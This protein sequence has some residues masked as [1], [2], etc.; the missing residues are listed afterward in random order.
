MQNSSPTQEKVCSQDSFP[1]DPPKYSTSEGF[2][3][4]PTLFAETKTY[5]I[6]ITCDDSTFGLVI[7]ANETSNRA[8]INR[9][10]TKKAAVLSNNSRH[11]RL[12]TNISKVSTLLL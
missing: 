5:N 8:F 1:I 11:T 3:F 10:S 7:A 6:D 9:I 12:L 2:K 4:F